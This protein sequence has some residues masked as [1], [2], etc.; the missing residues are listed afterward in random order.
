[1]ENPAVGQHGDARQHVPGRPAAHC[2]NKPEGPPYEHQHGNRD[3]DALRRSGAEQA[4]Q[5]AQ[6]EVEQ[7]IRGLADD[8][9]SLGAPAFD[10]LGQP[11]IVNV[12]G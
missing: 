11:R 5:A 6:H 7:N 8:D 12:T 1:M 9:Q 3:R 4:E 10:Q 2:G